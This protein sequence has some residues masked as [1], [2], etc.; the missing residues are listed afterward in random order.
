MDQ[1]YRLCGIMTFMPPPYA[2]F[3]SL[4]FRSVVEMQTEIPVLSFISAVLVLFPL[5]G[6]CRAGNIAAMSIGMWLFVVNTIIAVDALHWT[7][8]YQ[9]PFVFWCDISECFDINY[10]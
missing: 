6:Y 8:A 4:D 10:R 5:P 2:L 9:I 1:V 7:G 3:V